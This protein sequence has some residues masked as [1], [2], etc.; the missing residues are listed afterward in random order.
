MMTRHNQ[1]HKKLPPLED[2]LGK[3]DYIGALVLLNFDANESE[4]PEKSQVWKGYCAFH[5]GDFEKA[6]AIYENIIQKDIDD[7]T[8]R[9]VSLYLACVNYYMQIYQ[10][11]KMIV[12]NASDGC[13]KNRILLHLALKQS[14]Y[15]NLASMS[16][17]Q[18]FAIEKDFNT[19]SIAAVKYIQGHYEE[20]IEIL[21]RLLKNN[22][23][24]LALHYYIAMCY[25]K[26]VGFV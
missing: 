17:L 10:E 20:A 18:G 5:L 19:I 16:N 7:K 22:K 26:L 25:F 2:F 14:E 12:S 8:K 3:R 9:D 6:K 15:N 24:Y 11:A 1:Q 4:E 23:V 21:K 13:L